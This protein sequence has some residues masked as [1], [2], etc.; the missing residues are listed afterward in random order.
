MG[1]VRAS[2]PVDSLI[3]ILLLSSD[4]R[5]LWSKCVFVLVLVLLGGSNC[6]SDWF[7]E[8]EEEREDEDDS[9]VEEKE[10]RE[11]VGV[12]VGI[13]VVGFYTR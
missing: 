6:D 5:V 4:L 3:L 13:V 7:L 2:V 9:C 10:Y 8:S 1:C 12:V 11:E